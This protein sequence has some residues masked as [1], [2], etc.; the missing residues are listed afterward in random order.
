MA[1]GSTFSVFG[2]DISIRGDVQ[3]TVD[4]HIDGAVEGD[5]SCAKLVQGE[6]SR[7]AGSISA[8]SARLAGTVKGTISARE[9]VI[10]KSARIEGDV[11]YETLTI[12]QGA[13]VD[14]RFAPG[15]KLAA[16]GKPAAPAI[17]L[18]APGRGE[19]GALSLAG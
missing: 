17:P 5:I 16:Q 9:L 15:A 11:H 4:L 8:E 1:S 13:T 3:A 10:L 14:G 6:S 2:A 12:E 7:I 18:D 19:P